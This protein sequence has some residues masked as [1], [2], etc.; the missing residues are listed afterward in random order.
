MDEGREADEDEN[1]TKVMSNR[2]VGGIVE[3]GRALPVEPEPG[4]GIPSAG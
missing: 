3:I 1:Q 4:R 2:K